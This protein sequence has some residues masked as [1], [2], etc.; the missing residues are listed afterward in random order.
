M[1]QLSTLPWCSLD[2]LKGRE[3]LHTNWGNIQQKE[4]AKIHASNAG[5]RRVSMVSLA[6]RCGGTKSPIQI[7]KT[8]K[9]MENKHPYI[10]C[11]GSF[12]FM[13]ECFPLI[14]VTEE[15]KI[16]YKLEKYP[17]K[18][19]EKYPYTKCRGSFVYMGV[20]YPLDIVAKEPKVPHNLGEHPKKGKKK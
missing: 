4:R 17:K 2:L 20:L 19:K 11:R 9:K 18:E 8:S 10:K 1:R 15:P 12:V 14:F 13:R 3:K 6:F 16:P 7:G 5:D